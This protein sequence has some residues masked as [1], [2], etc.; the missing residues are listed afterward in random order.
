[1][2]RG[3]FKVFHVTVR[4]GYRDTLNVPEMLRLARKQGLLERSLD[5]EHASYFVSRIALTATEA[6][7]LRAL[8]KKLFIMMA[9]NAASPIEA[10][11]L[12]SDRTVIMGGQISI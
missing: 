6:P 5:I 2:G 7:P 10:F 12:P 8:R 3:L 4:N 9:R 11:G 1:M